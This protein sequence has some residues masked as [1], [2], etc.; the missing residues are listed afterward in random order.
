MYI[1]IGPELWE[2]HIGQRRMELW[3]S[4]VGGDFVWLGTLPWHE[5]PG[6]SQPGNIVQLGAGRFVCCREFVLFLR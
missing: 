3:N 1:S 5:Q 4:T 6:G 2:V